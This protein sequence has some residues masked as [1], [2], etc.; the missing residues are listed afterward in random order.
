MP[1]AKP[2]L[3]GKSAKKSTKA[4]PKT[5]AV[6][7]RRVTGDCLIPPRPPDEVLEHFKG[8]GSKEEAQY[9]REYVELECRKDNER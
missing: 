5:K 3:K 8:E 6:S 1:K 7:N 9:I 2:P 4:K